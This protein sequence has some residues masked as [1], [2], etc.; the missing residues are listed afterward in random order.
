MGKPFASELAEVADTYGWAAAVDI[1]GL[2][3]AI[4]SI[5]ASPLVAIGS[6]GSLTVADYAARLHESYTGALSTAST[7]MGVA[8]SLALDRHTSGLLVSAGGRN[9]DV[10]NAARWMIR[11]EARS[12]VV[13]CGDETSPLAALTAKYPWTELVPFSLPSRKDGF[14]ATNSLVAFMTL[15]G[16]AYAAVFEQEPSAFPRTWAGVVADRPRQAEC[17]G[18]ASRRFLLALF[19]PTLRCAAL[20]L[21]SKCSEAGL[22]GVQLADYRNFAHGRHNWIARQSEDTAIV[23]FVSDRDRDVAS[24]TLKCIPRH[25]PVAIVD[26]GRSDATAQLLAV[27]RVFEIIQALGTSMGVDPGRPRVPEYGRRL[28]NLRIPSLAPDLRNSSSSRLDC[29]LARKKAASRSGFAHILSN[30]AWRG[31]LDG[32]LQR[33]ES[34]RFRAVALDY[35][36]TLCSRRDRLRGLPRPIARELQ[37]LL[38]GGVHIGIAT[39]RGQSVT[40]AFRDAL[41]QRTW[42]RVLIGYYNGAA[43]VPLNEDLPDDARTPSNFTSDI[44]T[45]L[46]QAGLEAIAEIEARNPQVTI[47]ALTPALAESAF[48]IAQDVVAAAGNPGAVV[49]RSSHSLDVLAPGV[50]KRS[51]VERLSPNDP[52]F[53]IGDAGLWPGNDAV[54]LHGPHSLSVDEVSPDPYSCWNLCAPGVR[55]PNGTLQYLQSLSVHDGVAQWRW[56]GRRRSS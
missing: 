15:L 29:A 21:E 19:G 26:V 36:G 20:D 23:A 5:G 47:R 51:L 16:R 41:D 28:Y 52:V 6:G 56:A 34:Q 37:R 10:L 13:L 45:R 44:A 35:D 14:L 33:M 18:L 50:T 11:R 31:A 43:V 53:C 27:A 9:P 42:S 2:A 1:S 49:A 22:A 24:R 46:K 40:R 25:V 32:F 48:I 3:A 17:D 54:F 39:G 38:D 55:G 12:L 7:P 4:A 8:E 30:D